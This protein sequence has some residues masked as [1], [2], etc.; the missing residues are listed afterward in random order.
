MKTNSHCNKLQYGSRLKKKILCTVVGEVLTDTEVTAGHS[1]RHGCSVAAGEAGVTGSAAPALASKASLH[2]ST[3]NH[4]ATR[5]STRGETATPKKKPGTV[6]LRSSLTSAVP[7]PRSPGP[8]CSATLLPLGSVALTPTCPR[9]SSCGQA[10]S[11]QTCSSHRLQDEAQ[12]QAGSLAGVEPTAL[13]GLSQPSAPGPNP[14]RGPR[15][16]RPSP[17][18][19]LCSR[20]IRPPS[21]APCHARSSSS[22]RLCSPQSRLPLGKRHH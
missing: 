21:A 15:L 12:A 13:L 16:P 2:P 14:H 11:V 20:S 10:P 1:W 6:V 5:G 8:H 22:L 4:M 17:C 7:M 19:L 3:W 9:G 18:H